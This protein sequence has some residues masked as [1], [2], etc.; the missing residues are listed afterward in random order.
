MLA[1]GVK[2]TDFIPGANFSRI[3][4][5]RQHVV[6]APSSFRLRDLP[7]DDR[8]SAS[9]SAAVFASADVRPTTHCRLP[10]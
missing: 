8:L 2:D 7:L 10:R 9:S 5:G 4:L 3:F 6:V 1:L